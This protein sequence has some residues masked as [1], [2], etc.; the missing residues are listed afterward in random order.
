MQRTHGL[1]AA[2]AVLLA[3]LLQHPIRA[4]EYASSAERTLFAGANRERRAQGLPAFH[5]DEALARAARLHAQ[6][7]AR[8]GSVSHQFPGEPSL[9]SRVTKAGAR[10]SSLAENVDSAPTA[11]LVHQRLMNSALHRANILDGDLDSAGIGVV[12]RRGELFVV[13]DFCKAK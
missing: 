6:R 1:V 3:L 13:E 11:W 10:F 5:W 4:Q 7:M 8:E 2:A 12:E 9:P